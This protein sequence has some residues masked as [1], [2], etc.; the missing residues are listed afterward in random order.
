MD[1]S[2]WDDGQ[3]SSDAV[4][5][6]SLSQF[7]YRHLRAD[8]LSGR[9][10]PGAKIKIS[11][12]GESLSVNLSAVREAL[13]RLT[14]DGLVVALPQR[15]FQVAPVSV[16]E[17]K[18][19]TSAR[20]EIDCICIRKAA[21]NPDIRWETALVAAT[22]QLLRTAKS[23]PGSS[24]PSAAWR[25]AHF[26]FHRALIAGCGNSWLIRIHDQLFAQAERYQR[27]SARGQGARRSI[28]NEHKQ[29][30]D[31]MLGR[32]ADL[33]VELIAAH[34]QK[35]ADLVIKSGIAEET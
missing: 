10:S 9:L 15:G 14:A 30:S 21:A 27:L 19:L 20:I 11:E 32:R 18:D 33:C 28:D 24:E 13:S 2:P 22:H 16:S 7:A 31:A 3:M 5:D 29:L 6:A 23:D 4:P 1:D 8:L 34:Y 17:L 35:T 12:V 25:D 26:E